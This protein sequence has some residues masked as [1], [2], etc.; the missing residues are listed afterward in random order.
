MK[1]SSQSLG[2]AMLSK[3]WKLTDFYVDGCRV[4]PDPPKSIHSLNIVKFEDLYAVAMKDTITWYVMTC[5]LLNDYR[6]FGGTNFFHF[7]GR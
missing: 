4:T 6:R 2:I 3:R 5:S 1:S 7:R